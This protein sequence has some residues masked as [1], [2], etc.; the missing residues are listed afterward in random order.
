MKQANFDKAAELFTK[1]NPWL[2]MPQMTYCHIVWN[3]CRSLDNRKLEQIH[4]RALRAI[5][6]RKSETYDE[7]LKLAKLPTSKNRQLQDIAILMYKVKN[8]LCPSFIKEIIIPKQ[9]ASI[10]IALEIKILYF[11]KSQYSDVRKA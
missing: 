9:Y 1:S 5:Y 10:A 6:N 3:F 11:A 7:L 4:E 8:E 2:T